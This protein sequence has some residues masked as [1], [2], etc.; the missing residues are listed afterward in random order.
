MEA[1]LLNFDILNLSSF[2]LQI[3]IPPSQSAVVPKL[4]MMWT[5]DS[6]LMENDIMIM[7]KNKT[8]MDEEQE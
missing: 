6:S 1:V 2:Q 5:I 4:I 7:N 3:I 8:R